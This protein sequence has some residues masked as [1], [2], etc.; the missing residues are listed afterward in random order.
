MRLHAART[1]TFSHQPIIF[2][3]DLPF[4]SGSLKKRW[5]TSMPSPRNTTPLLISSWFP[6]RYSPAGTSTAPRPSA[7]SIAFWKAA[8]SSVL[9]SA[10][11]P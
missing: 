7:A 8:A 4:T 3:A 9:P 10:A 6:S 1:P 11:A 2:I 5:V